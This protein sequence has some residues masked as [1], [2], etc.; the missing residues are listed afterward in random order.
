MILAEAVTMAEIRKIPGLEGMELMQC[1]IKADPIQ[2][3]GDVCR[4]DLVDLRF[5]EPS[6]YAVWRYLSFKGLLG[7]SEGNHI[8][9]FEARCVLISIS[10][11]GR[12]WQP[13]VLYF[14]RQL[15][16]TT[17][18]Q[19]IVYHNGVYAGAKVTKDGENPRADLCTLQS[20][21]GNVNAEEGDK[22]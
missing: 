22:P 6:E 7:D 4:L 2:P 10:K 3:L 20:F 12:C 1:D 15:G 11:M 19:R 8:Y 21:V 18:C 17:I 14:E 16:S 5:N 9:H 13:F